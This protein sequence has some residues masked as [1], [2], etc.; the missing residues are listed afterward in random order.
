MVHMGTIFAII[1]LLKF[2]S[3]FWHSIVVDHKKEACVTT[4]TRQ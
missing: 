4:E 3:L 2:D 1:L